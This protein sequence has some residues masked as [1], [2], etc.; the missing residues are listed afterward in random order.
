[1]AEAGAHSIRVEV[2]AKTLRVSK[3]S[4]Y[5]HFKNRQALLDEMLRVWE[6]EG[7]HSIIA[8]VDEKTPDA[9]AR[10]K[11]L[12]RRVYESSPTQLAFESSLRAWAASDGEVQK[13][14]Q[15]VDQRRIN[16]VKEL[17]VEA[18]IDPK[19]ADLRAD[20]FYSALV[21]DMLR[22]TY[23]KAKIRSRQVDFVYRFLLEKE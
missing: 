14:V 22:R 23:G 17:L 20:L 7:T 8:E 13:R 10:L 5:W 2:L 6:E 18:K 16:Y 11:V 9:A 4:F 19:T 15:R 21:G 1:M 3:G 12:L